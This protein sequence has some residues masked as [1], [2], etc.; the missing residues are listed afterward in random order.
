[1]ARTKKS[2]A[3]RNLVTRKELAAALGCDVRTTSRFQDEGMPVA[4]PGKGGRPSLFDLRACLKWKAARDKTP[5]I[6]GPNASRQRKEL[7]QAIEAEQRIA[8]KAKD[9]VSSADVEQMIAGEYARCR[10]K[11]LGL[12][13]KAKAVLPHLSAKDVMALDVLVREALE[14]LAGT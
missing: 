2:Q 6:A 10:T 9:L 4:K 11:L 7:A 14:D 3:D 13:R 12:P 5:A 8:I 1:M